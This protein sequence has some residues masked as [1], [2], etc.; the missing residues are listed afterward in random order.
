M[1]IKA[2]KSIYTCGKKNIVLL[3]E[4]PICLFF[5]LPYRK[6]RLID[7]EKERK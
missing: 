7:Q 1:K 3:Y 4:A 2:S 6:E 5:Y